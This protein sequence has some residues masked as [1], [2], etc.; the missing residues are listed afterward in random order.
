MGDV[1]EGLSELQ[2]KKKK[3]IREAVLADKNYFL[4]F[5]NAF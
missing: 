5:L 1:L 4:V 3:K 2:L